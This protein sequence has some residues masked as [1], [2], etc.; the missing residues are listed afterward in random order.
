MQNAAVI[1]KCDVYYKL[2]R[3]ELHFSLTNEIGRE[4]NI[5]EILQESSKFLKRELEAALHVYSITILDILENFQENI[6]YYFFSYSTSGCL[7]SNNFQWSFSFY[8]WYAINSIQ[9]SQFCYGYVQNNAWAIYV[10]LFKVKNTILDVF[11]IAIV[12][13]SRSQ[14]FFKIGVLKNSANFTGKHLCWN[15]FLIKFQV[16]RPATLLKRDS[17]LGVFLWNLWNF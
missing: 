5:D 13:S 16:R 6:V 10:T 15:L 1:R 14:K 11:S 4:E 7:L 3:Y 8:I 2:R 12:G 17:N 9:C